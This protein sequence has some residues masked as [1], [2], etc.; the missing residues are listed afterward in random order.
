MLFRTSGAKNDHKMAL[1]LVQPF[2]FVS[3]AVIAKFPL[4]SSHFLGFLRFSVNLLKKRT[5][6]TVFLTVSALVTG[7]CV[8][9]FFRFFDF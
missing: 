4:L 7:I 2:Y 3:T 1:H 8:V 5:F 6:S 9:H